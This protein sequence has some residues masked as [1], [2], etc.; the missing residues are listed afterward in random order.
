MQLRD[1]AGAEHTLLLADVDA[2]LHQPGALGWS[3]LDG[4]CQR[5]VDRQVVLRWLDRRHQLR[6]VG[7]PLRKLLRLLDRRLQRRVVELVRGRRRRLLSVENGDLHFLIVFD[8]VRRNRRVRIASRRPLTAGEPD[9][10]GIGLRHVQDLVGDRFD[11]F[12]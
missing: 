5:A 9:L 7:P 10:H 11:F 1:V 4:G 3:E 6:I 2:L 12:P 8:E